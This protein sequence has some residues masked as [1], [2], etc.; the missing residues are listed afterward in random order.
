LGLLKLCP[1]FADT[2]AVKDCRSNLYNPAVDKNI[3]EEQEKGLS[4]YVG[5]TDGDGVCLKLKIF[6]LL[7]IIER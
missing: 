6:Y 5:A 1:L 3:R 7:L 2:Y 4:L